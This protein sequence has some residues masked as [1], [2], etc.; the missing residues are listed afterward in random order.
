MRGFANTS[1]VYPKAILK[2]TRINVNFAGNSIYPVK[3]VVNIYIVYKLNTIS[4][5]R[6]TGFTIQNALLGALKIPEDPS[7]SSNDKYSGYGICFDEGSDFSIGN[8]TNSKNVIIFGC[9]LIS[10]SHANNR[11]NNIYVWGEEFIQGINGTTI[12]AEKITNIIL[13]NQIKNLFCL[14]ITMVTILIY[15]LMVEKN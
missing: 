5:T 15:L 8:I 14:Y 11:P 7:D 10:S 1:S 4:S 2:W 12:Y 9:D 3:S 13:Q 6:N